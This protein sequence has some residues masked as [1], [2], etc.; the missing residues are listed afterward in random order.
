MKFKLLYSLTAIIMVIYGCGHDKSNNVQP[1]P[2]GTY[3]G[4]FRLLHIHAN[5]RNIID[6]TKTNLTVYFSPVSQGNY[7]V[8]GDTATVHAGSKGSFIADGANHTIFFVDNTYPKAGT[9]NKTHLNG[10]YAYQ[11]DGS[12]L[13]MA[14][15][16]ALDTLELQ[17]DLKKT[18]N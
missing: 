1:V 10:S 6:T 12:S 17:Y 13:K 15:Y 4:Q 18:G 2:D 14:A 16:G 11:Y 8:T 5:N 7:T 3:S 9:P